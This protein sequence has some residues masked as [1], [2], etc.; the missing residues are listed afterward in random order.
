MGV[1]EMQSFQKGTLAIAEAT[2]EATDK[3]AFSLVGGGDSLGAI[4]RFGLRNRIG[5]V[6]TG[7][8]AMLE[9]IEGK[10]LPGLNAM[11]DQFSLAPRSEDHSLPKS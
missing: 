10:E 6:S 5:F 4:N 8:G 3:G 11:V 9:Y 2:A 7:G 1:F